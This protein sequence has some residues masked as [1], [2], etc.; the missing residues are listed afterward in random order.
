MTPK[1]AR[2]CIATLLDLRALVYYCPPD[3]PGRER[4]IAE[5]EHLIDVAEWG[6]LPREEAPS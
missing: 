1:V 5:L 2:V 3:A 4:L 6:R